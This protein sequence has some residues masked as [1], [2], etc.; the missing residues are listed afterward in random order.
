MRLV[1]LAKDETVVR[2]WEWGNQPKGSLGK[3]LRVP[4]RVQGLADMDQVIFIL[5]VEPFLF[6]VV[7]EKFHIFRYIA[8]LYRGQV[9]PGKVGVGVH[10]AHCDG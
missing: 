1:Q 5:G 9:D 4:D 2:I 8:R 6:K 7:D 10:I 3:K